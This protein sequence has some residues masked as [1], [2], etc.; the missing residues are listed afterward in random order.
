MIY[1]RVWFK[2][3]ETYLQSQKGSWKL[4]HDKI[5]QFVLALIC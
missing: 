1:S 4:S 5:D 2:D 3:N